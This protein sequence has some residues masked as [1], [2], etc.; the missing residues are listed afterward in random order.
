MKI[1]G[2]KIR[3]EFTH[4]GSGLAMKGRILEWFDI[5]GA[6]QRFEKA[7]AKIDGDSVVVW[8]EVVGKPVAVRCAW[9][10]LAEP[11]LVNK[12]GLPASPFRTDKW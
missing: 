11:Q 12:E 4:V 3:V 6:D 9:H 5:A 2:D 10:M 8:S 1:E 7:H